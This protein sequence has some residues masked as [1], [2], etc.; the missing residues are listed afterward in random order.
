[1]VMVDLQSD[2]F[3]F[4][5]KSLNDFDPLWSAMWAEHQVASIYDIIKL[6]RLEMNRLGEKISLWSL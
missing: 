5:I 6:Q 3:N 2:G 1:M 4:Q